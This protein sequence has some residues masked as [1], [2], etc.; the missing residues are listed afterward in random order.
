MTDPDAHLLIALAAGQTA[1]LGTLMERHM[2]AVKSLAW[3]MLGDEMMAEDIAQDV[4]I[5]AWKQAPNWQEGRAK[6]STWL[7]RVTKNLCYD[8][9][10]KKTEI[11]SDTLP[12]IPDETPHARQQMLDRERQDI[13]AL[14]LNTALAQLAPRQRLAIVL[15]H[16]QECSQIDA[17]AIM[18]LKVRAYES[19]LAR[20]RRNLRTHLAAHKEE[21]RLGESS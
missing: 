10:R 17:A 19:L 13:Q 18:D 9:L 15:C 12:E 6:F 16:Y 1:A 8:K 5:R 11:L 21:L 14:H 4:F 3:H 2:G 7:F 20:G